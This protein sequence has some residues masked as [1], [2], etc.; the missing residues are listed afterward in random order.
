MRDRG[1]DLTREGIGKKKRD[2]EKEGA[3][4]ARLT[5]AIG[6]IRKVEEKKRPHVV[7][8]DLEKGI[9]IGT[10]KDP[11]RGIGIG[12]MRINEEIIRKKG[13]IVKTSMKEIDIEAIRE[14][15]ITIDIEDG[16]VERISKCIF[17]QI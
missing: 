7:E 17:I 14:T 5:Q 11:E 8:I 15:S 2:R 13:N 9:E 1:L 10:E 6:E 4:L 12:Q 3:D 16:M